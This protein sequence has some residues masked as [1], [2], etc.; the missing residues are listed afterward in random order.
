M[1]RL[2]VLLATLALLLAGCAD[3]RSGTLGPAPRAAASGT[4]TPPGTAPPATTARTPGA[5]AMPPPAPVAPPRT[6]APTPSTTGSVTVQLWFTRAGAV[7]PTRRTRPTT[8]AT[9]RL[10]LAELAAG[11]TP[12]EAAAGLATLVPD[13]VEMVRIADGTATVSAPPSF[14]DTDAPT[15]RL[16][17]AQVVWTLT[18]FPTVRR[19]AFAGTGVVLARADLAD[20]LPPIVVTE[21]A[22]GQRVTG[23]VT[24]AGTA[25]V[26]EATVSIRVLDSAGRVVGT[27]FTTAT[28][29][30]GCRG[31]YRG[32]VAYRLT[33]AGP[34]TVEVYEVSP[35]DGSR[36]HVVAVPVVLAATG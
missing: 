2:T 21:P 31:D 32:G 8:V 7:V 35:R 1:N 10:A 4:A 23:P 24:V 13:G 20:L 16:R 9:S 25:D 11:P 6:G 3:A 14:A 33:T 22:I 18:Q 29:G 5:T 15:L 36:T 34:G 19:V 26:Y 17:R 12:A 28:C 27:G 30:S